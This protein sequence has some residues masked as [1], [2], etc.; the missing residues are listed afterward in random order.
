ML[1]AAGTLDDFARGY[2]QVDDRATGRRRSIAAA[3]ALLGVEPGDTILA[4]GR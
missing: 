4:I 1:L 2:G 3:A